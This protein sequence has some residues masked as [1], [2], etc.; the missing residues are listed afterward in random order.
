MA[1]VWCRA[2]QLGVF[3]SM[4][5]TSGCQAISFSRLT[6]LAFQIR[7]SAK[8]TYVTYFTD[9]EQAWWLFHGVVSSIAHY[10]RIYL[11]AT[12]A[13][14]TILARDLYYLIINQ[15]YHH[16]PSSNENNAK[17]TEIARSIERRIAIKCQQALTM[18]PQPWVGQALAPIS[19][20]R[21]TRYY[22]LYQRCRDLLN[23]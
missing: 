6:T 4:K 1:G 13:S 23:T 3:D 2:R 17:P 20:G 18:Q 11:M 19:G 12:I 8:A 14:S 16:S 15:R 5:H 21:L 10:P 9:G 22:L 7:C